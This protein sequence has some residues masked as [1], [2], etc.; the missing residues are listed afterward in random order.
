MN[1]IL[2][3]TRTAA[4]FFSSTAFLLLSAA[5]GAGVVVRVINPGNGGNVTPAS[6]ER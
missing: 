6:P 2:P 1:V 4:D 3:A 5:A